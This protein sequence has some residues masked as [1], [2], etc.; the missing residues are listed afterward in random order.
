MEDSARSLHVVNTSALVHMPG[1]TLAV[2]CVLG[3]AVARNGQFDLEPQHFSLSRL[4]LKK[5]KICYDNKYAKPEAAGLDVNHLALSALAIRVDSFFY[6][7]ERLTMGISKFSF[8]EKCGFC[9]SDMSCRVLMDTA[10]LNIPSLSI[11][12]PTSRMQAKLAMDLNAFADTLPGSLSANLNARLGFADMAALLP[13]MKPYVSRMPYAFIDVKGEMKGNMQKAHVPVFSLQIPGAMTARADG[14]LQNLTDIDRLKGHMA[15][16]LR[17]QQIDAIRRVLPAET[18]ASFRL[19]SG[20]A[21]DGKVAFD[22]ARYNVKRS[23]ARV[24]AMLWLPLA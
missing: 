10:R 22:G 19:P 8:R 17:T 21:L 2:R 5:G 18:A 24:V 6:S 15:F 11:V 12:T 3:D 14:W 7:P 13:Y 20:M 16:A 1:D 4:D 9:L 23:C